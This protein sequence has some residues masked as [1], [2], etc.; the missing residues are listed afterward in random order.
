MPDR[1][2]IAV[3]N[4]IKKMVRQGK[5]YGEISDATGV[6]ESPIKR[7]KRELLSELPVKPDKTPEICRMLMDH[8]TTG[9]IVRAL[10]VSDHLVT[11]VR[12]ELGDKIPIDIRTA[13][14][15][16]TD[17]LRMLAEKKEIAAMFGKKTFFEMIGEN[18]IKEVRALPAPVWPEPRLW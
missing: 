10:H 14:L 12:K 2:T 9:E 6:S 1:I 15:S 13:P 7:I 4:Q 18:I 11:K 17:K 3:E 5:T 8:K 16:P